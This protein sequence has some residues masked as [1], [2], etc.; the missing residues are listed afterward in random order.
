MSFFIAMFLIV[1]GVPFA[2]FGAY[3]IGGWVFSLRKAG[4][5]WGWPQVAG[6]ILRSEYGKDVADDGSYLHCVSISYEYEVNGVRYESDRFSFGGYYTSW[7]E[8]EAVRKHARYSPIGKEIF[9][10]Y[11]PK[12]PA[13]SVLEPGVSLTF[14]WGGLFLFILGTVIAAVGFAVK[15]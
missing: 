10:Y 1:I 4:R 12:Q 3:M 14:L 8:H 11:D 5:S 2:V 7:N 6:K 15:E 13:F 9:V